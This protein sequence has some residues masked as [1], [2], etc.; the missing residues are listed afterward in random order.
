MIRFYICIS[1]FLIILLCIY[2]V[3][4][5]FTFYK[6][7][8]Q[9]HPSFPIDAVITF[10]DK[11]D[12]HFLDNIVSYH[13]DIHLSRYDTNN[14]IL[15]CIRSIEKYL[16]FIQTVYLVLSDYHKIPTFLNNNHPRLKIVY[17]SEIIPK[18]FL[19]TFNST[20]IENYI[21]LIPHLSEHFLYFNDDFII[22]KPQS[23]NRFYTLEGSPILSID[24]VAYQS[25]NISYW[26]KSNSKKLN[27]NV[28][29]MNEPYQF[30]KLIIQNNQLLDLIFQTEKNRTQIQ[31]IPIPMR[32]SYLKDLDKYLNQYKVNTISFLDFGNYFKF[33]HNYNLAKISLIYKYYCIYKKKCIQKPFK[34]NNL[35]IGCNKDYSSIIYN[36]LECNK[37]FLNV[38]NEGHKLNE[39]Y[40]K[41][42]KLL[43]K[44]LKILFPYKSSFEK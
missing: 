40:K 43:N 42:Y 8:L 11:N 3:F 4:S 37:D 15:Y 12:P 29:L 7:S 23:W 22:L 39:I 13:H 2:F 1:I 41:N 14:E 26:K 35:N 21:H 38:I 27:Y 32:I 16:D 6:E 18:T 30:R 33:R 31:H 9:I 10:V 17:H 34:M 44:V 24:K 5:S 19:P 25:N 36:I 28:S 20:V